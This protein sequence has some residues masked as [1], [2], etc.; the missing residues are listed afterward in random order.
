MKLATRLEVR[1]YYRKTIGF[2]SAVNAFWLLCISG[3]AIYISDFGELSP[4]TNQEVSELLLYGYYATFFLGIFMVIML[5]IGGIVAMKS[6]SEGIFKFLMIVS[7]I[8]LILSGIFNVSVFTTLFKA[9]IEWKDT[10]SI[11][12]FVISLV[13]GIITFI[14]SLFTVIMAILGRRYYDGRKD[15]KE[16]K[17]IYADR[18]NVKFTG[19]TILTY[20]LLAVAVYMFAF[21]FKNEIMI[22]DDNMAADNTKYISLFNRV[23]IAGLIMSVIQAVMAVLMFANSKKQIVYGNKIL[24]VGQCAVTAFYI[25]VCLTSLNKPFTKLNYPDPAYMIFSFIIIAVNLIIAIRT[26]R[27]KVS[28]ELS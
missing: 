22:Y 17:N 18:L 8:T 28:E 27:V 12:I 7:G 1:D 9:G 25:L 15:A 13:L 10:Y 4:E 23:F 26:F 2:L 24:M 6:N 19:Y 21:Y 3:L 14:Y 11:S 20:I 16:V 5:F